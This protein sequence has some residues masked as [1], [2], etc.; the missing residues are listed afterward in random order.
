MHLRRR[1]TNLRSEMHNHSGAE[2][3][4]SVVGV[5]ALQDEMCYFSTPRWAIPIL[6]RVEFLTM[7][8]I[9]SAWRMTS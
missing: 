5:I 1:G 2:R 3:Y 9:P 4:P 8:I 6:S 7:Y